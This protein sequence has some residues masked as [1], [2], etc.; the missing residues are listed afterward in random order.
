[1]P[2]RSYVHIFTD[3]LDK[4][5][6]ASVWFSSWGDKKA[7]LFYSEGKLRGY[8]STE[9]IEN[10]TAIGT[11]QF[12][13]P[14]FFAT[15]FV[16]AD[17]ITTHY[18]RLH[19][20]VLTLDK[21]ILRRLFCDIAKLLHDGYTLYF[22]TEEYMTEQL[23]EKKDGELIAQIG[24]FRLKFME[25]NIE[26]TNDLYTVA[27]VYTKQFNLQ[28]PFDIAQSKGDE[29]F[30]TVDEILKLSSQQNYADIIAERRRAFFVEKNATD[31][32]CIAGEKAMQKFM[33]VF[34]KSISQDHKLHGRG[35]SV[36]TV[37]GRVYKVSVADEHLEDELAMMKKGDILV[38]ESTQPQ[39]TPFC[40]KAKAIVTDEGGVLS[41]AAI[42]AREFGTPCVV[43]TRIAT[44][45]LKTGQKIQVDGK[46]G[47]VTLLEEEY[48]IS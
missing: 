20:K 17:E 39:F 32:V 30:L 6:S 2:E 3:G 40:K 43:G 14:Q 45:V 8:V 27:S 36:G 47:I 16:Q 44:M 26:L 11:Q 46:Q 23:D 34:H 28:K 7:F 37:T 25:T 4:L 15:M 10:L 42:L 9:G 1:M 13:D 18:Q 21:S 41:H 31:I 48:A 24:A 5:L 22:N 19:A 38:V 29:L 35:V 12:R 33:K